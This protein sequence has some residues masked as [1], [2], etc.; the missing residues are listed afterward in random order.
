MV[1][2]RG[3]TGVSAGPVPAGGV[4]R[5]RLWRAAGHGEG[6]GAVPKGGGRRL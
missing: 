5:A 4:L 1:C 6:V 2:R 3:E